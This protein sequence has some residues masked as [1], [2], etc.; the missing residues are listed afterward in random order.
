MWGFGNEKGKEKK[1][2]G[3]RG[4]RRIKRWGRKEKEDKKGRVG[5][6]KGKRSKGGNREQ[7][8]EVDGMGIWR[9]E[10]RKSEGK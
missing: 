3:E 1:W 9:E 4:R 8:D 2:G 7:G 5:K 10:N 6:V